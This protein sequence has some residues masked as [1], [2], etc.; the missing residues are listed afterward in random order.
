MEVKRL[1]IVG[2]VP[3]KKNAPSRAFESYFSNW[4]RHSIAQIFSNPQQPFK[5]HCNTLFQVTDKMLLKRWF[6][7]KSHVGKVYHF[8]KLTAEGSQAPSKDHTNSIISMLYSAGAKHTPLTH[9]LR[10]LLWKKNFWCTD[11]LNIWLERFNPDCV[12]LSFSDDFFILDIAMYVAE[13]F[14]IPIV[15]TISDDYYFNDRKSISP[16]YYIYRVKYKKLV[17]KI[18]KKY[19][20]A[21]YISEDRKSVV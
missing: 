21:I 11:E 19:K 10:A 15:S 16:L 8:D 4:P 14:D 9:L 1:L 20:Y 12:F 5:G 3:Y 18:F 7:S 13:K 2:T 6:N 17:N